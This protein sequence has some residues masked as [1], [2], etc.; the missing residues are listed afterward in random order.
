[1]N[2]FC[3]S[4][5][6]PPHANFIFGE[7]FF[8]LLMSLRN[9]RNPEIRGWKKANWSLFEKFGQ[10][11][12]RK[13][14]NRSFKRFQ[15]RQSGVCSCPEPSARGFDFSAARSDEFKLWRVDA[16]ETLQASTVGTHWVGKKVRRQH[17]TNS[18]TWQINVGRASLF[19]K[20]YRD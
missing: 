1:M 6:V 14:A 18:V 5:A 11:T 15:N 9:I 20:R 7:V 8:Q 17:A 19:T 13:I 10:D 4:V 16:V 3:Y 12:T 2:S